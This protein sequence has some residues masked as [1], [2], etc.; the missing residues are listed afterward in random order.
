MGGACAELVCSDVQLNLESDEPAWLQ[1]GH[2]HY[3][4]RRWLDKADIQSLD[5]SKTETIG[6]ARS[7]DL[8]LEDPTFSEEGRARQPQLWEQSRQYLLRARS[9]LAI[10]WLVEQP[11]IDALARCGLQR[12]TG[13][14]RAAFEQAV[15]MTYETML[16]KCAE[17]RSLMLDVDGRS[18]RSD[19]ALHHIVFLG[20]IT[21]R[22][23]EMV[24]HADQI[25]DYFERQ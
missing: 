18:P 4:H 6:F 15:G 1:Y 2:A 17:Y 11:S 3:P 19:R 5:T 25:V 16:A 10:D 12:L 24:G 22:R 14:W 7:T 23:V 9:T 13:P 8:P 21:V 20:P